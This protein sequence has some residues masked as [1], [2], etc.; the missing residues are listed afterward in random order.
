MYS[1]TRNTNKKHFC[2]SCLQ[3]F[4][5]EEILNIIEKDVY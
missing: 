3:N 4:S 2:M 5:A 1:K